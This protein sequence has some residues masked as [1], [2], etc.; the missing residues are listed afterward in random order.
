[1]WEIILARLDGTCQHPESPKEEV[2]ILLSD[3]LQSDKSLPEH[4]SLISAFDTILHDHLTS[5]IDTLNE[6]RRSSIDFDGFHSRRR[7]R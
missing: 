6:T 4:F 5:S 2:I 3:H 7:D 1:M